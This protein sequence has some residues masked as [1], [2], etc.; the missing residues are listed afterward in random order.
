MCLVCVC[1]CVPCV[2][3]VRHHSFYLLLLPFNSVGMNKIP[4]SLLVHGV[5][6]FGGELWYQLWVSVSDLQGANLIRQSYCSVPPPQ[7]ISPLTQPE[8]VPYAGRLLTESQQVYSPDTSDFSCHWVPAIVYH[9]GV[10]SH[11]ET[12]PHCLLLLPPFTTALGLGATHHAAT[13]QSTH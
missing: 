12:L 9:I 8:Q 13:C 1:V 4:I 2:F 10:L 3:H 11:I 7:P 6:R 5:T